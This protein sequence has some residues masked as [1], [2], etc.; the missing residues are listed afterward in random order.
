ML[1]S[2]YLNNRRE[3]IDQFRSEGGEMLKHQIASHLILKLND[4]SEISKIRVK[5]EGNENE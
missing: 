1:V 2:I 3:P 5:V 4:V